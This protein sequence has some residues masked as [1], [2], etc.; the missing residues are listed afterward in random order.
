MQL[1]WCRCCARINSACRRRWPPPI[2]SGQFWRVEWSIS[3]IPSPHTT[4]D[5]MQLP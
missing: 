2:F 1:P 5:L 3:R 4:A